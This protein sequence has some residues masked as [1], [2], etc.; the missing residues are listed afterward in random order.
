MSMEMRENFLTAT[1]I[2]GTNVV[3][4]VDK[5]YKAQVEK[6]RKMV[7]VRFLVFFVSYLLNFLNFC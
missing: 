4:M 1:E 7:K 6:N 3:Q 2:G 5:A